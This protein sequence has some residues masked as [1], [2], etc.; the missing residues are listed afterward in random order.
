MINNR[1]IDIIK[2]WKDETKMRFINR[3]SDYP[4][5]KIIHVSHASYSNGELSELHVTKEKDEGTAAYNG[6]TIWW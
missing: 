6:A 4:N 3:V 2:L 1:L 5:K